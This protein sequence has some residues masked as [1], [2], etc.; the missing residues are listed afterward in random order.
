MRTKGGPSLLD[1]PPETVESFAPG[2]QAR[3]ILQ[4]GPAGRAA[5]RRGS[6]KWIAGPQ[7]V[8]RFDLAVDPEELSPIEDAGAPEGIR[9]RALLQRAL[10][11]EGPLDAEVREGLR[12]LG[13]IE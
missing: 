6:R 9:A 13:Y 11:D 7:G 3:R 4:G 1:P 5:V 8:S 10:N 2:Q 12:R